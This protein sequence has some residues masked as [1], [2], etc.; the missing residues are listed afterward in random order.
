MVR[1]ALEAAVP[2][3]HPVPEVALA[4]ERRVRPVPRRGRLPD[5]AAR[6]ATRRGPVGLGVRRYR[7]FEQQR[8]P[9]GPRADGKSAAQVTVIFLAAFGG[10]ATRDRFAF[11]SP[12]LD[13]RRASLWKSTLYV[14]RIAPGST[15]HFEKRKHLAWARFAPRFA[16]LCP[17][18]G[19]E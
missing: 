11:A 12:G 9:L 15:E 18:G 10:E 5:P 2:E 16:S 17:S 4:R 14:I 1:A 7:Q 6:V 19:E 3:R 8:G 13:D